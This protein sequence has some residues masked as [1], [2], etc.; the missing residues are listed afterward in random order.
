VLAGKWLIFGFFGNC[1]G[2]AGSVWV[3]RIDS[4]GG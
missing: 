1:S 3:R 2:W 4:I